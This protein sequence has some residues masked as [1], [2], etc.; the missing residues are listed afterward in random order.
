[1]FYSM[2]LLVFMC[3]YEMRSLLPTHSPDAY[4]QVLVIY[5]YVQTVARVC[6]HTHNCVSPCVFVSTLDL[7]HSD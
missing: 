2:V 3:V 1:M 6:V 5:V 4:K 7:N